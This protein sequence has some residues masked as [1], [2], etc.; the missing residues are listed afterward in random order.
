MQ[1]EVILKTVKGKFLD[2]NIY[3][4]IDIISDEHKKSGII[5][6]ID[7]GGK[8][9]ISEVKEII[10]KNPE[11]DLKLKYIICTHV[12]FDHIYAIKDFKAEFKDAIIVMTEYDSKRVNESE[13][14]Y[15]KKLKDFKPDK[16]ILKNKINSGD[17][18]I[19]FENPKIEIISTPRT[20]KRQLCYKL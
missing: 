20:Y 13:Y 16:E 7:P 11:I 3:I 18:E 17:K 12:H 2:Q 14:T 10:S 9:G 5:T 6:V 15:F 8:R 1:R 4:V 19:L